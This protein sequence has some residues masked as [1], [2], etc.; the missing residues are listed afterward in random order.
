MKIDRIG[1]GR[2]RAWW[3]VAGML[4]V[5]AGAAAA[6]GRAEGKADPPPV[7]P[8]AG[9]VVLF[10]GKD[11]SHWVK[12]RTE[13]PAPWP[14]SDGVW[15][16]KGGDIATKENYDNFYLHLEWMEPDMPNAR[17]Q[18]KGNSGIGLQGRYEIQLL[19]S[20][21]WKVPGKGDCGAVYGQVAPLINACKPPLQWQTMDI[22]YRAPRVDGAGML[23]EKPR[24]TVIQNGI[25]VQDNTEIQKPTGIEYGDTDMTKPGPVVLQDHGH[26]LKFRS[27]WLLPL[28]ASGSDDYNPR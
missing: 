24:V 13:Q 8:V 17:G 19:D 21:G 14:V 16:V 25:A 1:A 11:T 28:P 12:R 9:A 27:I 18:A 7:P 20:Y 2:N 3:A 4:I 15:Q 23:T 10:D 5:I 22:I 6:R 26:P